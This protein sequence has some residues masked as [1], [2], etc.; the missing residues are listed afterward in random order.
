[1]KKAISRLLVLVSIGAL[2]ACGG[3]EQ[4]SKKIDVKNQSQAITQVAEEHVGTVV[5]MPV[6]QAET[7]P[8]ADVVLENIV[9]TTALTEVVRVGQ[10]KVSWAHFERTTNRLSNPV[11]LLVIKNKYPTGP[12][13]QEVNLRNV[14]PNEDLTLRD[15]DGDIMRHTKYWMAY[16]KD[17]IL[18][19]FPNGWAANDTKVTVSL[20]STVAPEAYPA[21]VRLQ[22]VAAEPSSNIQIVEGTPI[23]KHIVWKPLPIVDSYWSKS[24]FTYNV[25]GTGDIA[26]ISVTC[27]ADDFQQ[28]RCY[29]SKMKVAVN[30]GIRVMLGGGFHTYEEVVKGTKTSFSTDFYVEP[31]NTTYL[32][33]NVQFFDQTLTT[34]IQKMVFTIDGVDVVPI[35]NYRDGI[36][37]TVLSALIVKRCELIANNT[38]GK[39]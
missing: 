25:G 10:V 4:A 23:T 28:S 5:S 27:P 1:M 36:C 7:T 6:D 13:D 33:L 31:W 37:S 32:S 17:Q 19:H 8:T 16:E 20:V 14:F 29:L 12:G 34:E 2:S 9:Q 24:Q 18:I 30:G 11:K 39:G 35:V 21:A 38:N 26:Y 15:S 22:L 3:G